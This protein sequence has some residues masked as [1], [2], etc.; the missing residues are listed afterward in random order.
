MIQGNGSAPASMD[1]WYFPGRW[2]DAG[3]VAGLFPPQEQTWELDPAV[4]LTPQALKRV[5]RESVQVPFD[6]AA[7]AINEDWGTRFDGK[8]MQRWSEHVG[9]QAVALREA[10]RKAYQKKGRRP[11]ASKVTGNLLVIGMDGGRMQ[12]RERVAGSESRWREDKIATISLCQKGDGVEQDPRRLA[13]TYTATLG[14]SRIFGTLARVE[15]ERCG[16]RQVQEAIVIGDGAAWIDTIA[17]EHFGAHERIVDYYH[18]AERLCD[19]AKALYPNNPRRVAKEIQGHL[20]QGRLRRVLKWLAKK[21][22]SLGKVRPSDPVNHPRRVLGENSGYFQ[23]HQDQMNYP[24]YRAK[25]W[26]IGSGVTE[27]GVKLFNKRVKGTEQFWSRGGG[28]AILAL[29]A[30][31]LSQDGRWDNFLLHRKLRPAA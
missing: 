22:K 16:I 9:Q 25:G 19:C 12:S 29:R 15:A 20:Y 14:N 18:A 21:S 26:P 8:H 28:E 27:S 11:A 2:R 10:E 1:R 5:C 30:L 7:R 31:R 3:H 23:K 17:K 6:Q 24:R 13:T 4:G